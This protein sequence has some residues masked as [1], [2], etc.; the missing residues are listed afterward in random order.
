MRS[1]NFIDISSAFYSLFLAY[2][3]HSDFYFSISFRSFSTLITFCC[4][5]EFLCSK[6]MTIDSLDE[7]VSRNSR[8]CFSNLLKCM[9]ISLSSDWQDLNSTWFLSNSLICSIVSAP[10]DIF[11]ISRI[12]YLCCIRS[13]IWFYIDSLTVFWSSNFCWSSSYCYLTCTAPSISFSFLHNS[14]SS[15]LSACFSCR[16]R[17]LA[18][19]AIL[20]SFKISS[21]F[22]LI[23]S[24][25][26]M[27]NSLSFS[28]R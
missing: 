1:S 21:F 24:S 19:R 26:S 12:F 11:L 2:Y 10:S 27:A 18:L 25:S 20:F 22:Y 3:S 13:L 8:F 17:D 16:P 23:L 7:I 15:S 6:F 5:S 4:I 14:Q 9:D 28:T